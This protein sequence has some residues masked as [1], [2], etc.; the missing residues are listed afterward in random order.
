[1]NSDPLMSWKTATS[2]LIMFLLSFVLLKADAQISTPC[3][4]C[5]DW[6]KEEL[7]KV[8]QH[9]YDKLD[10]ADKVP[11][12]YEPIRE[13]DVFWSKK[14]WRDIDLKEKINLRFAYPKQPFVQ[15]LLEAVMSGELMAYH[16]LRDDFT[17]TM[18]REEVKSKLWRVDTI[19][20]YD[21]NTGNI[22][23]DTVVLSEPSW[24]R[25]TKI[26]ILE[27]WVFDEEA[28]SIV[29]RILGIAPIREYI[30]MNSGLVLGDEPVCWIYYPESRHL[31]A[32]VES[33]NPGNDGV[34]QSW[35]DIMEMRY[36]S[37]VI[38]KENNVHDRYIENYAT[39]VD[40]VLE[41]DRIKGDIFRFEHELWEY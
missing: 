40:G 3:E 29:V 31:L 5:E 23:G 11:L 28:S 39:G 10:L 14:I 19:P 34:R 18:T 25:F 12:R 13:A 7:N 9:A 37:S 22:K 16:P 6:E 32:T 15:I 35:D 8:R 26:R 36:F 41:S 21:F 17:M 33:F 1:M 20:L 2:L 38:I 30:D 27:E 24:S 4:G